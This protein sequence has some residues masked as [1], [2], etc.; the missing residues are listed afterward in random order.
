MNEV[1]DIIRENYK[2]CIPNTA[3]LFLISM[4]LFL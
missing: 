3:S 1:R 4:K 2:S